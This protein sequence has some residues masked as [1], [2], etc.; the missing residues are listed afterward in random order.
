ME[1]FLSLNIW[2]ILKVCSVSTANFWLLN[3]LCNCMW[4]ILSSFEKI[5]KK[6]LK[7]T[8]RYFPHKIN[9][10]ETYSF[11][12]KNLK[13][14]KWTEKTMRREFLILVKNLIQNTAENIKFIINK[15]AL[16][17][18]ENIEIFKSYFS[19]PKKRTQ[20]GVK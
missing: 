9:F 8:L 6:Y 3:V 5:I 14:K 12:G 17:W 18:V 16:F 20:V 11:A 19:S 4:G 1:S 13:I 10:I 2:D 7:N 15:P